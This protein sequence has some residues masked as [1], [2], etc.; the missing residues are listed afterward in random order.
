MLTHEKQSPVRVLHIVGE[1]RFGGVASIILGLGHVG[2][3]EGWQ[4]DVLTTDPAVQ[5]AVK[6]HG[7]G[8]VN[9]DVIRRAIRPVWDLGGLLR[10]IRF[11]RR[12]RYQIVHTHTSKGGFV[13]PPAAAGVPVIATPPRFTF[14]EAARF[15][16]PDLLREAPRGG[17][18]L[19]GHPSFPYLGYEG[20]PPRQMWRFPMD[21]DLGDP[22]SRARGLAAKW[23]RGTA[24]W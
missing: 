12:E 13:A 9:L 19:F 16:S 7:L 4:V 6:Q 17:A 21:P 5:Q 15:D 8:L 1:S 24:T 14:H 23:E 18:G 2:Q 11:L 22:A 20:M 3:A 10:L